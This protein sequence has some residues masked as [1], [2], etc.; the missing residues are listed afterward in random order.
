ML[1]PVRTC[2][3]Y[4]A[5]PDRSREEANNINKLLRIKD[6]PYQEFLC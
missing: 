3:F 6:H 2:C 4:T 1:P 5:H